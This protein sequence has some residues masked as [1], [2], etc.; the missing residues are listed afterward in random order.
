VELLEKTIDYV[1]NWDKLAT[2]VA[3]QYIAV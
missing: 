2:A 3:N 1:M